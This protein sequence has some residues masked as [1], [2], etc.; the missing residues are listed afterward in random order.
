MY[1]ECGFRDRVQ[2]H[3]ELIASRETDMCNLV[4]VCNNKKEL[5]QITRKEKGLIVQQIQLIVW[6]I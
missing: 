4:N 2:M 5:R 1:V 3:R 6:R